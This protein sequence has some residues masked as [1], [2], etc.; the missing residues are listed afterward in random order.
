MRNIF[1]TLAAIALLFSFN[2][3]SIQA[4]TNKQDDQNTPRFEF[5]GQFY[6]LS[7]G[8]VVGTAG[9]GGRFTYNLNSYFAIDTE[10]NAS[11]DVGDETIGVTGALGFAGVKAGR[12]FN[13]VGIFAKA[14]PGFTTSFTRQT[15]PGFFDSERVTKPAFDLGMVLEYYPSPHSVV[16]FDASDVI[17]GFGNDLI[18]EVRCPC[19]R[20]IGTKH[21]LYL[22]IGYS[23]RF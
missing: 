20:R 5:G 11:I 6:S 17:V 16:R 1:L 13:K 21:G 10:L 14:R 2:V 8:D 12:R 3:L 9:A 19:P 22:S 4:Q 18:E 7:L 15:G 23:F